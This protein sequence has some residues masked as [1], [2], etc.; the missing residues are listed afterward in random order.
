M[1]VGQCYII[2]HVQYMCV[3]LVRDTTK[4]GGSC[5]PLSSV[6]QSGTVDIPYHLFYV[7]IACTVTA[8][9]LYD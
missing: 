8:G 9:V 2:I 3:V 6:V 5:F 4:G 1:Y 7:T